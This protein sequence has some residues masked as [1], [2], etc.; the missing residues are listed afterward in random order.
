MSLTRSLCLACLLAL[1]CGTLAAE[2]LRS[3]FYVGAGI[4][5]AR[6]DDDEFDFGA[7][8]DEEDTWKLVGGYR[9]NERFAI[10]GSY[11]DFGEAAAPSGLGLNPVAAEAKA[12]AVQAVGIVPVPFIDLYAKAGLARMDGEARGGNVLAED[13][14][15]EFTFG[16]GAQW[17]WKNLALRAE[18][19]KFDTDVIGDLD[20]ISLGATYTFDLAS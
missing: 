12:F 15:T 4:A 13:K 1:G 19:E 18:Y 10:E 8:D 3:G 9:F 7:I 17:R 16:A 14:T 6:F 11:L 20:L 5:Q 2:E